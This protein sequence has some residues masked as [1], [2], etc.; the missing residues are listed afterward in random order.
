MAPVLQE[1][2]A[3]NESYAAS[4]GDKGKLVPIP[5]SPNAFHC[6]RIRTTCRVHRACR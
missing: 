6:T 4:F 2:L 3:A 5:D 1:V